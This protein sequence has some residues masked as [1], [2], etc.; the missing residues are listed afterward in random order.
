M[1]T[2]ELID[3]DPFDPNIFNWVETTDVVSNAARALDARLRAERRLLGFGITRRRWIAGIPGPSVLVERAGSSARSCGLTSR[4]MADVE[5]GE[6]TPTWEQLQS[7]YRALALDSHSQETLRTLWAPS[8]QPTHKEV[9]EPLNMQALIRHVQDGQQLSSKQLSN[10]LDLVN[11]GRDDLPSGLLFHALRA[12]V[13]RSGHEGK[14]IRS[15]LARLGTPT[16]DALY[17]D[18]WL[19]QSGSIPSG[20]RLQALCAERECVQNRQLAVRKLSLG[21]AICLGT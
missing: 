16:L 6:K 17:Q 7:I 4:R 8:A 1:R 13:Q 20:W 15:A 11:S 12:M 21:M 19:E 18:G 14:E 5:R 9:F 10:A 3:R 2:A